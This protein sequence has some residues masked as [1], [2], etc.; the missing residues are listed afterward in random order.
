MNVTQ[1]LLTAIIF[2]FGVAVLARGAY[3]LHSAFAGMSAT[4][5]CIGIAVAAVTTGLCVLVYRKTFAPYLD[6]VVKDSVASL[7]KNLGIARSE[8]K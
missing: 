4:D 3:Q 2:A 6:P 8:S 5:A 7:Q 1:R